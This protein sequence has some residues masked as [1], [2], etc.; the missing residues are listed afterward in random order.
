MLLKCGYEKRTYLSYK[1]PERPWIFD[2]YRGQRVFQTDLLDPVQEE[3]KHRV[4]QVFNKLTIGC[5][6]PDD[7]IISKM[8]RG[9]DVDVQDS[10]RL[11]E[12]ENIDLKALGDR[13]IETAGYYYY[14]EKTKVHLGYL[15]SKLDEMGMNSAPLKE[16]SEQWNP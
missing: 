11:I 9:D 5:L 8:F 4:V 14:P 2:L 15:I 1:H 16:A 12:S 6:N 13:Y 3:G 10:I 7:L